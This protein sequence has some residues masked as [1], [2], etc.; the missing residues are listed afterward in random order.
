MAAK[1]R[2]RSA[3]GSGSL[4]QRKDG[5]WEGRY[6]YVDELGA[7][8]R[9]SVYS[10]SQS[11]CQK[12]LNAAL[13]A[14]D[15]QE[16]VEKPSRVTLQGW[17]ETWLTDYCRSLKPATQD[18]Y[19]RKAD[20]HIIPALGTVYLVKLTPMQV[21]R[22]VN[23]LSDG[24]GEQ[25]GLS[26]K[27][28]KNIHGI[29]H[30]ALKQAVSSGL[31]KTNPADN[32]KLPSVKKPELKPLMDENVNAFL[33]AIRGHRHENLF[34]VALFTGM[35]QSELLGLQWR[36]VDFESARVIVRRQLQREKGKGGAYYFVDETKSGKDRIVP[37]APSVV[38]VLRNQQRQQ[39][40]WQL[41]AGEIWSN[42]Y[43][44]IFTDEAGRH[45]THRSVYHF[46][47][48]VV[49]EIGCPE[50]RFHDLRHSCAILELQAGVPVKAVQEQL[51]HYS[52]AFT[53]DVYAAVSETMM[54]DTRRRV[55]KIIKDATG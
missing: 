21:Q 14:A 28:V 22:W 35:R 10:K 6:T 42:E 16:Q 38:K 46:F 24:H 19:K 23:R 43:G 36:D 33:R 29:L 39:A 51:G 5:T 4:R 30:S 2:K 48:K 53:M 18:D 47:K 17:F 37:L 12:K 1:Q 41:Q 31:L 15:K 3:A 8:R 27:S 54:D 25:K 34:L 32:T 50:V 40:E 55:E 45:L 7:T 49:T 44:L 20:R 26:P 9:G 13:N 52:S 11:D